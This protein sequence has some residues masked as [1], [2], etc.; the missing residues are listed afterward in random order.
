MPFIV[1]LVLMFLAFIIFALN[2]RHRE[3]V[4]TLSVDYMNKEAIKL[5]KRILRLF[6]DKQITDVRG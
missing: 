1:S 3:Q 5:S 4:S 6:N 2:W